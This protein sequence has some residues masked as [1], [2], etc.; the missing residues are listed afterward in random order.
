MTNEAIVSVAGYIATDPDYVK[1]K[2]GTAAMTKMRLAWTPRRF[3]RETNGWVDQPTCFV[4]V[5]CWRKLAD[6]ANFSLSKGDPVVVSGTLTVS[7]YLAKDGTR[8]TSVDITATAIGHDLTRGVTSI[9]R[10]RSSSDKATQDERSAEADAAEA[11]SDRAEALEPGADADSREFGAAEAESGDLAIAGAG[12]RDLETGELDPAGPEP[13]GSA[14]A[15]DVADE[16]ET[17]EPASAR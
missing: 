1:S 5:K 2:P 6:N 14:I 17:P 3:D 8:R 10:Q 16:E 7:E 11:G 12:A 13:A 15:A 4:W 9:R